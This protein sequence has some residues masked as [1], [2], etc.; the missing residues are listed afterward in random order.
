MD[1]LYSHSKSIE[2]VRTEQ[3]D[4]TNFM[5]NVKKICKQNSNKNVLLKTLPENLNIITNSL[6]KSSDKNIDK[7]NECRPS[8]GEEFKILKNT[9]TIDSHYRSKFVEKEIPAS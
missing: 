1:E 8:R 5:G 7:S 2:R 9:V 6:Y 3:I 4:Q